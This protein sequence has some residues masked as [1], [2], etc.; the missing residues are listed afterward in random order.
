[1]ALDIKVR[2]IS[3]TSRYRFD[4]KSVCQ[5]AAI[6]QSEVQNMGIK[7][8]LTIDRVKRFIKDGILP[9][10][11]AE[12]LRE[13]Q[14][15][16]VETCRLERSIEMF[17]PRYDAPETDKQAKEALTYDSDILTTAL[18]G[19]YQVYRAKGETVIEAFRLALLDH[20]AAAEKSV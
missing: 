11:T 17:D 2:P 19:I 7:D 15:W 1:M 14:D 12:E 18:R 10:F 4:R 8:T 5:L 13:V 6:E 3:A 9:S 16:L 20:V